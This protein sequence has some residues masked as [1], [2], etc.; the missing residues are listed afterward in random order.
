MLVGT[1][2]FQQIK[3]KIVENVCR[4]TWISWISEEKG[5]KNGKCW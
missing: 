2:G 3:V 1:P 5:I 4:H